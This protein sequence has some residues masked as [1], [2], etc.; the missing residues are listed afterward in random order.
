MMD[1]NTIYAII[2]VVALIVIAYLYF[3]GSGTFF[4]RVLFGSS[5]E[6]FGSVPSKFVADG[7]ATN[8]DY[9]MIDPN[10]NFV[11]SSK[12]N[13]SNTGTNLIKA[14]DISGDIM[15]TGG[16]SWYPGKKWN[17]M[18]Y[19]DE[20]VIY[21]SN[22]IEQLFNTSNR[23]DSSKTMYLT[24]P[25]TTSTIALPLDNAGTVGNSVRY[26]FIRTDSTKSQSLVIKIP[27]GYNTLWLRLSSNP[28]PNNTASG[29]YLTFGVFNEDSTLIGYYNVG[30]RNRNKI[31]PDGSTGDVDWN[32]YDWVAIPTY[33]TSLMRIVFAFRAGTNVGSGSDVN[34][35]MSGVSFST[36]PWNHSYNSAVS[37]HWGDNRTSSGGN[38]STGIY[39]T[40][41]PDQNGF[42]FNYWNGINLNEPLVQMMS[43]N[44]ITLFVPII[45]NNK[46]KLLYIV[47]HNNPEGTAEVNTLK[48]QVR[49]NDGTLKDIERFRTTYDN[50]FSRHMSSRT[51][52][53]YFASRIPSSFINNSIRFIEVQIDLTKTNRPIFY[54]EAGTHDLY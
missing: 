48:V 27:S 3:K 18:Y 23:F 5:S 6:K 31:A 35:F 52:G 25:S 14:S 38:D 7:V 40:T 16:N 34:I 4:N 24:Y 39:P 13:L 28:D 17:N 29:N 10:G 51:G 1:N 47:E 9:V 44:I 12:L 37:Y 43:G 21:R 26:R 8:S 20:C 30:S 54:R 11:A 49:H 33:G 42:G 22:E 32:A 36:N 45:P 2:G 50:P 46:D 19:P 15:L 53:R 41:R